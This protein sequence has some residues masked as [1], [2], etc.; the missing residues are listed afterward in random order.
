MTQREGDLRL[1][2]RRLSKRQS[3]RALRRDI[4]AVLID[5]AA[6]FDGLAA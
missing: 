1:A 4:D 2:R 5:E 3:E 6:G